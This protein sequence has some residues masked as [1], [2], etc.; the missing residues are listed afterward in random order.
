MKAN[1]TYIGYG[2]IG[3]FIIL[4]IT[5]IFISLHRE[6]TPKYDPRT[7][8][9]ST[10]IDTIE[11]LLL[12]ISDP[13]YPTQVN[14]LFDL[15]SNR[16]SSLNKNE[17]FTVL[18]IDP[19]EYTKDDPVFDQCN[20]GDGEEVSNFND[21]KELR[22]ARFQKFFKDKL[23]ENLN[24]LNFNGRLRTSPI[25]EMIKVATQNTVNPGF[26][27]V[28]INV[29][30]DMIQNMPKRYTHYNQKNLSF[31]TFLN[32]DYADIVIPQKIYEWDIAIYYLVRRKPHQINAQGR[33]H[34]KWW[35]DYISQA[36]A[37]MVTFD[38]LL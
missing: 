5:W 31:E 11:Y 38:K 21:N 26:K 1:K 9:P 25:L 32:T 10:G 29:F 6:P 14:F 2:L 28:R 17:K 27:N 18:L 30:S 13:I 4:F 7:M 3:I 19:N 37:N 24:Q 8:C 12:D 23:V 16:V 35:K 36:N 34:I 20:P 33:N 15:V 22:K